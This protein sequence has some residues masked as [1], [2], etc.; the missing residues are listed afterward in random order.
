MKRH[1]YNVYISGHSYKDEFKPK[2]VVGREV[3]GYH[4]VVLASSRTEALEKCLPD[5]KNELP[6]VKG[7]KYV[8]VHVGK[9]GSVSASAGRLDP[10]QVVI[11]TGE[12]RK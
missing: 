9:K 8:S 6:K 5:I 4:R 3:A 7:S 11:E 10:I 2:K 12:I 1:Y